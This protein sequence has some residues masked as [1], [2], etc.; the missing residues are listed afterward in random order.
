MPFP[1]I[2]PPGWLLMALTFPWAV[3]VV[4]RIFVGGYRGYEDFDRYEAWIERHSRST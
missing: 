1:A 3:W 4:W 2:R